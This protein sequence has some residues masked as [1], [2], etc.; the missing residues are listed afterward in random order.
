[1]VAPYIDKPG[2]ATQLGG[3][4]TVEPWGLT[5]TR[6]SSRS[7]V[8]R[9][10]A[11]TEN[12]HRSNPDVPLTAEVVRSRSA[13]RRGIHCLSVA[14]RETPGLAIAGIGVRLGLPIRRL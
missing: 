5:V 4:P 10:F 11:A 14:G 9:H 6:L 8:L 2:L 13:R 1:M 12:R 7:G 3:T